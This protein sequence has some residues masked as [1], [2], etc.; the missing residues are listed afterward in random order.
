MPTDMPCS[1]SFSGASLSDNVTRTGKYIMPRRFCCITEL[2]GYRTTQQLV[3]EESSGILKRTHF[4][5]DD[6]S[7]D[8]GNY[9]EFPRAPA[10]PKDVLLEKELKRSGYLGASGYRRKRH[11]VYRQVLFT[12][13]MGL[14]KYRTAHYPRSSSHW[15]R[16]QDPRESDISWGLWRFR[17]ATTIS[18]LDIPH[19]VVATTMITGG[20]RVS[21]GLGDRYTL[22]I[23]KMRQDRAPVSGR[24]SQEDSLA[25]WAW[26]E[27][28]FVGS[29]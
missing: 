24:S 23:S 11:V 29:D 16:H 14:A 10:L 15:H 17:T 13:T 12:D 2:A 27:Y 19:S 25:E 28:H 20:S 9:E 5:R 3:G 26:W 22:A 8:W 4:P 1:I 6:C 7:H 18:F 21:L